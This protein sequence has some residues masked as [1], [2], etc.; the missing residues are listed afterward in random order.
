MELSLLRSCGKW[1]QS[2]LSPVS[3]P[4]FRPGWMTNKEAKERAKKL[5]YD[6]EVKDPPFKDSHGNKVFT[7]GKNFIT[8]DRDVH[9][10]GA[11]KMFDSSGNRIGTYDINL[12]RIGN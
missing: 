4:R 12:N 3:S 9:S 2:R 5:G 10:G 1:G 11:W 8:A 7:N 6:R